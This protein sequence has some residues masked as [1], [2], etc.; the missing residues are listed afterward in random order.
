[1]NAV[2]SLTFGIVTSVAVCV[3]PASLASI[4]MAKS[5]TRQLADLSAPDLWTTGLVRVDPGK[6][7]Y[8]RI[9]PAYSS[10]VTGAPKVI[11]AART[12]DPEPVADS[13]AEPAIPA[14]HLAWCS[15]RYRSYNPSTNNYRAFSGEMRSCTSPFAEQAGS[16][17]EEV[18]T[19]NAMAG[20]GRAGG[21]ETASGWCVEHYQSYRAQDN[22][23]QPFEGPRRQC[24]APSRDVLVTASY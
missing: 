21:N 9:A 16:S 8:Q 6:Q 19:Q 15:H 20:A 24:E 10:Y 4:V 1:M 11:V 14:E 22:S 17:R 7:N 23:Y 12:Q 5:E 3:V 2:A 13:A 18:A